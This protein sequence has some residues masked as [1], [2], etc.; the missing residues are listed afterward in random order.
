MQNPGDFRARHEPQGTKSL[1]GIMK[2]IPKHHTEMDV[3]YQTLTKIYL[4]E[5]IRKELE[6]ADA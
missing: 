2:K 3:P 1:R 4:S 5:R 6:S